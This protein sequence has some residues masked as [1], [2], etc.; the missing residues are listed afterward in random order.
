MPG[1]RFDQFVPLKDTHSVL[2]L[3]MPVK[4]TVATTQLLPS[5][6]NAQRCCCGLQA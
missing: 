4:H 3:Q 5:C 2:D 6:L 1:W